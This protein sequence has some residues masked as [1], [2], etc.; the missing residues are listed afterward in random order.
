M[1]LFAVVNMPI[2]LEFG[3]LTPWA[4]ISDDHGVLWTSAGWGP[5]F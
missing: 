4:D 5:R 1:I 2:F 3:G